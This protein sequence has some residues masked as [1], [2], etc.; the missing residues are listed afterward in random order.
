LFSTKKKTYA[1]Y[2]VMK[3]EMHDILTAKENVD[4][5]LNMEQDKKS[6]E[7]SQNTR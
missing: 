2:K 6:K 1:T 4:R 5:L 3:K 7:K